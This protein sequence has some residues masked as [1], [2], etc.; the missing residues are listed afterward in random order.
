M[1]IEKLVKLKVVID[2]RYSFINVSCASWNKFYGLIQL[3]IDKMK[4]QLYNDIASK[5]QTGS[6]KVVT[7]SRPEE[8]DVGIQITYKYCPT[9]G[10]KVSLEWR[11]Q[12]Y[13]RRD[14]VISVQPNDLKNYNNLLKLSVP[15]QDASDETNLI[16]W[17]ETFSS[18]TVQQPQAISVTI[19]AEGMVALYFVAMIAVLAL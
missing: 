11:V 6:I 13:L 7:A 3:P 14:T 8:P 4:F 16:R 1:N 10:T 5:I 17:M 9:D 12:V 19:A 18:M 15:V 2:I